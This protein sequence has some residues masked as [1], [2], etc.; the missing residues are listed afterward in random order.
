M[1]PRNK[2]LQEPAKCLAVREVL[3]RI[4]DKWSVQIVGCLGE[5]TMRF[6]ELRRA[7]DGIS[8]R[9]LTLT[10]RGLERDGLIDRTVFPEIPPRVEY[11]LTRLGKTLL[12]PIQLL[13]E[14]AGENRVAIQGA[15]DRFDSAAKKRA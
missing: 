5:G 11:A 9:M 7:I 4:G 1:S 2:A 8:Q 6:S 15:R 14:W 10:L 3:N 12:E 13:A